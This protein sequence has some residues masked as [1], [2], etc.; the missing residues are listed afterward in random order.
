[1]DG[2]LDEKK[3]ESNRPVGVG[4][5]F[6]A[7]KYASVCSDDATMNP[8]PMNTADIKAVKARAR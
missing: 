6:E 8:R 3:K 1:M 5:G 2:W 4:G 7:S